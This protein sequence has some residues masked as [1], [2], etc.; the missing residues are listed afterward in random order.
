MNPATAAAL[1]DVLGELVEAAASMFVVVDTPPEATVERA[2]R[3][4]GLLDR[5]TRVTAAVRHAA[6]TEAAAL[7]PPTP[8]EL[9]PDDDLHDVG[10]VLD[11]VERARKALEAAER[12][13]ALNVDADLRYWKA[14]NPATAYREVARW[15]AQQRRSIAR[16]A[17]LADAAWSAAVRRRLNELI[18]EHHMPAADP[19]P[20]GGAS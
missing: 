14:N 9:E 13:L 2:D 6:A 1:D 7:R 5:A 12:E 16:D 15:A 11:A 18:A 8:A 19:D 17:L 3:V 10:H 20:A 4:L